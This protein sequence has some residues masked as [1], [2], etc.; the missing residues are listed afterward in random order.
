MVE[1]KWMW[2]AEQAAGQLD[3]E[4]LSQISPIDLP[5]S[6]LELLS[7]ADGYEG[8]LSVVPLCLVLYPVREVIEIASSG[9][10]QEFFADYFVVGG[11]G[12]G[13]AIAFDTREG[14]EGSIVA[15]DITNAN[16]DTSVV[17]VASNFE[18]L[19]TKVGLS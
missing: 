11:N 6:Y 12:G 8:G 9:A 1:P 14:H 13:E 19:L 17:P 3:L 15:F 10:F 5:R 18:D 16:V 2:Q 4:R 7:K